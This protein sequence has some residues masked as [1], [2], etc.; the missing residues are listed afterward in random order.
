MNRN[1]IA[2]HLWAWEAKVGLT[3]EDYVLLNQTAAVW[4]LEEHQTPRIHIGITDPSTLSLLLKAQPNVKTE[5]GWQMS[6]YPITLY[7]V[8]EAMET[9]TVLRQRVCKG[10]HARWI[11]N[12]HNAG[13]RV[14]T[15][16]NH[17]WRTMAEV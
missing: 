16:S 5:C 1:D 17:H 11:K 9:R 8:T 2:Q 13:K 12:R 15:L 3:Y 4:I 14:V 6:M 7:S 10:M